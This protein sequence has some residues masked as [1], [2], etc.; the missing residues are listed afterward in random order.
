MNIFIVIVVLAATFAT[1]TSSPL[2]NQEAS[3][4]VSAEMSAKYDSLESS[5]SET[6]TI[7]APY[8]REDLTLS[9]RQIISH[10][11]SDLY[12]GNKMPEKVD[13]KSDSKRNVCGAM[14]GTKLAISF[15]LYF[16]EL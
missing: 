2:K 6:D 13:S 15:I 14:N 11:L 5:S 9:K 4:L 1:S 12:R 8:I 10:I 7:Y 16:I 3:G